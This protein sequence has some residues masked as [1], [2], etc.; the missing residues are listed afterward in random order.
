MAEAQ[1][2][3]K[4]YKIGII[5]VTRRPGEEAF[6]ERLKELGYVERRNLIIERRYS[7][8]VRLFTF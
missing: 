8:V 3:G 7:E 5:S 1:Q 4:V 2:A 6:I